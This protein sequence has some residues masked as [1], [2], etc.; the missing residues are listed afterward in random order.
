MWSEKSRLATTGRSNSSACLM[1]LM[2]VT[3]DCLPFLIG[4]MMSPAMCTWPRRFP[5]VFE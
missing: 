3:S 1:M 5:F 2:Y 4:V